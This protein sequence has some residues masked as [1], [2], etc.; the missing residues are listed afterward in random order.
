MKYRRGS[1]RRA[2]DNKTRESNLSPRQ[3][4]H[5]PTWYDWPYLVV[6]Q[7]DHAWLALN[8]D[9]KPLGYRDNKWVDYETHPARQKLH[10]FTRAVALTLDTEPSFDSA[11][12]PVAVYLYSDATSP[13]R[14]KE[15]REAYLRRLQ[16]LLDLG[17][18]IPCCKHVQGLPGSALNE[19]ECL[20]TARRFAGECAKREIGLVRFQELLGLE[21]EALLRWMN[22]VPADELRAIWKEPRDRIE[23]RAIARRASGWRE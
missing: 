19:R 21:D 10:G 17:I 23:K 22:Q 3:P 8:R 4:F 14:S 11:G 2:R 7:P 18:T 20:R 6:R 1:S 9:Y 13:R 15:L 5:D 16:I 12:E